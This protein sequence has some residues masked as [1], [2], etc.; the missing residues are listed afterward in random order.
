MLDFAMALHVLARSIVPG[1]FAGRAFSSPQQ[2]D[3]TGTL[4]CCIA[5]A[6]TAASFLR[7]LNG[8]KDNQRAIMGPQFAEMLQAHGCFERLTRG[9]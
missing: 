1:S 3:P 2:D 8:L 7:Q 9:L 4:I 5:I 6:S